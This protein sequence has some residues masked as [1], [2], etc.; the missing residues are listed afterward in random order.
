M[1]LESK[2]AKVEAKALD[3]GEGMVEAVVSVTNIVDNVNDVIVPGAY[4][5]TLQKRIPK[6]V[7]SH[8]TTVPVARTIAAEELKPGDERLPQHLQQKEAGGV[9]VQPG[10]ETLTKTLNSSVESKNGLLAILFLK[11]GQR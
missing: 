2:Q 3:D 5:D 8:D 6:G 7:W 1:H 4:K 9:L 11:A 10:E